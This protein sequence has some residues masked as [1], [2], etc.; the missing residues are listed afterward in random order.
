MVVL[1]DW[2]QNGY[3]WVTVIYDDGTIQD[4]FDQQWGEGVV[5]VQ[6]ALRDTD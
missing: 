1:T 5:A 3:L 6:S 2:P 4:F